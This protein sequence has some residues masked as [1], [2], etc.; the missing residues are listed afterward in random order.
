MDAL[1]KEY[2]AVIAGS[3]PGG[4]TVARELSK[5]GKKVLILEW[6]NNHPV[7]GTFTQA[8]PQIFMPG[9]SLYI[10]G[11]GLGM[12]RGITTGGS[13]LFYCAT[14]FDPPVAMLNSFGVNIAKE[15]GEIQTDVPMNPLSDQLMSPAGTRFLESAL[16]LGYDAK[17]LN[18]FIYQ[19]KCKKDCD[20]CSFGCPEGAKWTARNFVEEAMENGAKMINYVKVDKVIVE[21]GKAV[22]LQFRYG[23]KIHKVYAP[24][25]I[26]AAGGIGSPLILRNTGFAG[27]GRNF[28]F[29]PLWFVFGKVKDGGGGK[30][31]QMCAGIHFEDEGIVMTDFNMNRLLKT[32]FDMQLFRFGQVFNYTNVVPIMIKVRDGLGGHVSDSGWVWKSLKESDKKKLRTG[33][34]HAKKILENMGAKSIYNSWLLA[35]HPGGTVKIGEH[36][37]TNL[38]TKIENLY[39]CDCSVIPR[40]WGLPPTFTI[41]ALGK[42]LAKHLMATDEV[43]TE[44]EDT[45]NKAA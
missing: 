33:R 20:A 19:D 38:Q 28:F 18:K 34:N 36:L 29:D 11:Q 7:K 25:V 4:A 40:E 41:L 17:K 12:V 8:F 13:S 1:D 9:K 22:G 15:V 6:G 44:D 39:V 31:I 16:D 2:D 14:A 24:Q 42:R 43:H 37:D 35:A 30:G 21:D 45:E 3:G 27:V 5:N 32:I 23:G 10:T 26:I